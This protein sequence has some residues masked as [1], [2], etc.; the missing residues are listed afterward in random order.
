MGPAAASR[1]PSATGCCSEVLLPAAIRLL[2][3]ALPGSRHPRRGTKPVRAG[4]AAGWPLA[5]ALPWLVSLLRGGGEAHCPRARGLPCSPDGMSRSQLRRRLAEL[6]LPGCPPWLVAL[7]CVLCL[8]SEVG[9]TDPPP[10]GRG[11]PL[12]ALLHRCLKREAA[13]GAPGR[14]SSC[15]WESAVHPSSGAGPG[16]RCPAVAYARN[17]GSSRVAAGCLCPDPARRLAWGLQPPLLAREEGSCSFHGRALSSCAQGLSTV[18]L[19][20]FPDPSQGP[21]TPACHG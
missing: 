5:T 15:C 1:C 18:I 6:G 2:S 10:T 21:G 20:S 19:R 4:A 13:A 17:K 14:S 16:C 9:S 11:S 7:F 3:L 8:Q 12:L